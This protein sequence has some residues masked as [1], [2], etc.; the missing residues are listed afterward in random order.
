MVQR[1]P[2]QSVRELVNIA[3]I[4]RQLALFNLADN[5]H[6]LVI[7]GGVDAQLIPH[8]ADIAVDHAHLGG[9]AFLQVLE[10]AGLGRTHVGVHI[11][12]YPLIGVEHGLVGQVK[13]LRRLL[14]EQFR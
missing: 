5:L 10:H 9:P 13:G 12:E 2:E 3:H 6:H 8:L 1:I 4:Q 7:K 14:V 11:Q